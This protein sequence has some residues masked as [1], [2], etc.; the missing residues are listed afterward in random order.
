MSK[1]HRALTSKAKGQ[2]R[3]GTS[4]SCWPIYLEGKVPE[5]PKLVGR[6]PIRR[7]ITRIRFKVKRSTV[8]VTK[9]INAEAE[10]VL[11]TNFKLG[12]RFAACA[13]VISG[14]NG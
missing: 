4:D 12:R 3:S 10:S 9:L 11:P 6:L 5:T 7:A 13:I 2:D 8:K 1:G 14:V